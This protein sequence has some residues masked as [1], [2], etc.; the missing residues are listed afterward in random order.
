M[1]LAPLDI[2]VI[3]AY[4]AAVLVIGL[5]FG[6]GE[7]TTHDF[8]LGG[9]RQHWLLVA[10]SIIATEVSVVTFVAVPGDSFRGDWNYLQMY[11]GAFLG[12]VLIVLLL[13]PA[14]YGGAVTTVYEYLG[15][16]FGPATRTTAS[17]M[18]IASRVIGSGIRLLAAALAV[19]V[20]FG[21]P[22]EW[23]ILGA[24]G[25]AIAYT[26]F[27]GIKAV[28]WTDALQAVLFVS[29][30]G[31]ALLCLFR[32]T[33]GSWAENLG[34]AYD[35]GKFHTFTWSGGFNNDKLFWVLFISATVQ[36][37]AAL[38]VDQDLTQRMLTCPD[39]RRGQRSVI[40]NALLGLPIVCL[41][42]L[43]GTLLSVYYGSSAATALP[44]DVL[45]RSD[46]IFPHFIATAL[47]S[48]WGLRGLLCTGVFAA[49]MSSLDS[50]LGALSSTAV[51]DFYRPY[52]NANASERHYLRI[53]RVCTLLFGLILAG[54]ALAFVGQ[55]KL[56][57]QVFKW[58]GLIFGGMLG[59]FLLGVTT[60]TRGHDLVNVAAMLSSVALLA[61]IAAPDFDDDK[62]TRAV[63]A[64]PWWVVI[65][66]VWT[67]AIGACFPT[68]RAV[69]DGRSR[70]PEA[71]PV[72]V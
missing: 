49:A 34:A 21:W 26:T 38:G 19:A 23:V 60:R 70:E 68:R 71:A 35:A 24:A 4:F 56:L 12:R 30:A 10:L 15:Q 1:T 63:I 42:L 54:V 66:T 28:M 20:I 67:Y 62:S 33:P 14:F 65:G 57:W 3:A 58:A 52:L 53:A 16:R 39:L 9:R 46:R 48:G 11:A 27:G 44:A 7:R 5:W 51:T 17:L 41:F 6:R 37:L 59:I 64:W 36:N 61:A 31:A 18:F 50:A 45:N 8:F 40:F 2:A 72:S 22:V 29:A 55:D 25:V 32:A 13:L 47:P 69:V 43:I